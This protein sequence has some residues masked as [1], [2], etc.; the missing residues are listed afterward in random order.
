MPQ[1]GA[2]SSRRSESSG[3]GGPESA[4]KGKGKKQA[5]LEPWE[6]EIARSIAAAEQSEDF[7]VMRRFGYT[8]QDNPGGC[9]AS[10]PWARAAVAHATSFSRRARVRHHEREDRRPDRRPEVFQSSGAAE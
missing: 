4:P 6:E 3:G 5:P 9:R 7:W 8:E 1:A 10:L 2:S